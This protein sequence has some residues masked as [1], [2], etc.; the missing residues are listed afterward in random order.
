[1]MINN[2]LSKPDFEKP[3][4][5]VDTRQKRV[6]PFK[7]RSF[8]RRLPQVRNLPRPNEIL[9]TCINRLTIG[10]FLSLSKHVSVP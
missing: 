2:L 8:K 9:I 4:E 1:M 7:Y 6:G 10:E 3:N 5:P